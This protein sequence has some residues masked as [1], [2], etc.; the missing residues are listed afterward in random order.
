MFQSPLL[1]IF[2]REVVW[3]VWSVHQKQNCVLNRAFLRANTKLCFLWLVFNFCFYCGLKYE[4]G[5]IQK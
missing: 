5:N 3:T 4:V 1:T 2:L